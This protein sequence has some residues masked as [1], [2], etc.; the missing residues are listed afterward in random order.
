M[1]TYY[2]SAEFKTI[3]KARA[4]QEL[5]KHGVIDLQE[6]LDDMGDHS[7]YSAQAVLEW[8]GY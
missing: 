5:K 8:L 1:T 4:I 3:T 2:D 7:T 6:F